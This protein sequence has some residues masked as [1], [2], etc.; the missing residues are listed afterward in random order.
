MTES[1]SKENLIE[2]LKEK[3]KELRKVSNK[4]AKVEEKYVEM[5]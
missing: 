2:L 3:A 5:H 4:L 1:L